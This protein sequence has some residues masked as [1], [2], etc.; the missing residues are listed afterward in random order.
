[1]A[2]I[3]QYDPNNFKH[4]VDYGVLL[5]MHRRQILINRGL[6]WDIS[7][8]RWLVEQAVIDN[9]PC[10]LKTMTECVEYCAKITELYVL[11]FN[12]IEV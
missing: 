8:K 10:R 1:M 12:G 9:Y 4:V 6:K 7:I 3:G 5:Q 11:R 2:T